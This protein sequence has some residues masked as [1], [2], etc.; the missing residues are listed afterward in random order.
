MTLFKMEFEDG[1]DLSGTQINSCFR[2]STL[3]KAGDCFIKVLM[4][5]SLTELWFAVNGKPRGVKTT[6]IK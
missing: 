5:L 2:M 3:G 4:Y 1:E 6:A